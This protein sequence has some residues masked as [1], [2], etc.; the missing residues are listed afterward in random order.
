[1]TAR[2]LFRTKVLLTE[3]SV[4]EAALRPTDWAAV[5]NPVDIPQ[6]LC[7][8]KFMIVYGQASGISR[9]G[10]PWPMLHVS[11]DQHCDIEDNSRE[12]EPRW[13]QFGPKIN[14]SGKGRHVKAKILCS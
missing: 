11:R 14:D 5:S 10:I 1:M 6:A 8:C 7:C 2:L 3:I 13:Q 4:M 12:A 9:T